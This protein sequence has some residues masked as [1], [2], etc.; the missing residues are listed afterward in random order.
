M[1]VLKNSSGIKPILKKPKES[2]ISPR[3]IKIP[4][5]FI[6]TSKDFTNSITSRTIKK[7]S[8]SKTFMTQ[9]PTVTAYNDKDPAP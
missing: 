7:F 6:D 5:S 2:K 8:E 3:T 4:Q 1:M 9:P